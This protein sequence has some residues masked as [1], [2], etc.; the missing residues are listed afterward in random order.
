[1]LPPIAV[2]NLI[3]A[4]FTAMDLAGQ[5]RVADG[6]AALCVGRV[7]ALALAAGKPWEAA[8]RELWDEVVCRYTRRYGLGRA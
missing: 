1:V 3:A 4:V 8:A 5:G 2:G 7:E 6:Y